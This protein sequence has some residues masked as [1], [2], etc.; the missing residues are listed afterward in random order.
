MTPWPT[1]H[2]WAVREAHRSHL[3]THEVL[4]FLR[5]ALL[6]V[7]RSRALINYIEANDTGLVE[8]VIVE[9]IVGA[10]ANLLQTH[11]E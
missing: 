7:Q 10:V 6:R 4:D 3:T 8:V 11:T 2:I 9:A 5:S 1:H